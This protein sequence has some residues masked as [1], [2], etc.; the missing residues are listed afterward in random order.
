M[1]ASFNGPRL[2]GLLV[3]LSTSV[4]SPGI[5]MAQA[6]APATESASAADPSAGD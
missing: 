1:T 2:A 3:S 4:A 5:A 6:A